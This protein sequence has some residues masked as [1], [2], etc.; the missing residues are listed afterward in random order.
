MSVARI[1]QGLEPARIHALLADA[2]R[3]YRAGLGTPRGARYLADRGI[4]ESTAERYGLGYAGRTW[5]GLAEVID[6]WDCDTIVASGL[7][8]RSGDVEPARRFDR[9][10]DRVMFPIRTLDGQVAGF[11]GRL[12][13]AQEGQP[14]YLNS[15]ESPVFKKRELLY[16]LHEAKDAI[17]AAGFAVVVEG[18]VDVLQVA[19]AGF[20]A[21]VGS[22]GTACNREQLEGLLDLVPRITFCFDGDAA[23]Q[24]AAE[25]ALEAVAPLVSDARQVRFAFLPEGHDPDSFVRRFGLEA[26]QEVLEQAIPLAQFAIQ[27]VSRDCDLRFAEGRA[28][29]AQRAKPLWRALPE[30]RAKFVL[31]TYCEQLMDIPSA[32]LIQHWLR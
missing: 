11:G 19:Q 13:V 3:H 4:S 25:R 1:D 17:V 21:V 26:F 22:L 8:A 23:G 27:C 15:P 6:P 10:R 9:F 2:A 18:F 5:Q 29:C 31:Q 7:L 14:K 16:G 28:K 24:R 12:V 20:K 30:G 32:K